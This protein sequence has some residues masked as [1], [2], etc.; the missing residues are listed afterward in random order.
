[1]NKRPPLSEFAIYGLY[2]DRD[3]IIPFP[4]PCKI[5]VSE[6]GMGKTT[7]LNALHT[8]L[9]GRFFKLE[10]L[11]FNEIAIKFANGRQFSVSKRDIEELQQQDRD[12]EGE[13]KE[14][15]EKI[16]HDELK[17]LV[18]LA[19]EHSPESLKELKALQHIAS[20]LHIP[21]P[22]LAEKVKVLA[23][24]ARDKSFPLVQQ[25]REHFNSEILYQNLCHRS[26]AVG[27]A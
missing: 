14:L 16:A 21:P 24:G 18:S 8:V 27:R 6:N 19:R 23:N 26:Q 12:Y 15:K 7:V 20:S 3:V 17:K 4:Y 11:D 25:V 10:N 2:G 9:S 1:M 5:L 22:L 13:Y